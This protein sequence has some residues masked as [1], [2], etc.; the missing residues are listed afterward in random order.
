MGAVLISSRRLHPK[1][2]EGCSAACFV[3]LE[4]H[5]KFPS[6]V[7]SQSV[8]KILLQGIDEIGN[9]S[10]NKTTFCTA[11]EV[12]AYTFVLLAFRKIDPRIPHRHLLR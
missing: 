11:T 7:L 10:I 3:I 12:F 5:V 2:G 9:Y 6:D 8:H 1:V 4:K